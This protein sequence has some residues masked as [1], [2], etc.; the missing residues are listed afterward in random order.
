M[1]EIPRVVTDTALDPAFLWQAVGATIALYSVPSEAWRNT[2]AL[3]VFPGLGEYW[4]L[5][6]AIRMWRVRIVGSGKHLLV[7]GLNTRERTA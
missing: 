5:K 3:V 1:S 7:T 2:D 4:R 6:Q